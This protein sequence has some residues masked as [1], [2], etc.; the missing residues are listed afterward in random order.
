VRRASQEYVNTIWVPR[1]DGSETLIQ[2][3][4]IQPD[5]AEMYDWFHLDRGRMPRGS[6]IVIGAS[7]AKRL[8]LTI[9]SSLRFGR[10]SWRVVGIFSS[11][12][13][14]A[15]SQIW[16]NLDDL[17]SDFRRDKLS[18]VVLRVGSVNEAS[19]LARRIEHDRRLSEYEAKPEVE[20]YEQEA[21]FLGFVGVLAAIIGICMGIG[22]ALGGMNVFFTSVAQRT[23]E[24]GMLRVLGFPGRSILGSFLLEAA[25]V[26]VVG[27]L[28]GATIGLGS[29]LLHA[30][31]WGA[32][33]RFHVT[34]GIYVSAVIVGTLFAMFG[35][36]FPAI[37]ASRLQ[38]VEA[39]RKG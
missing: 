33:F 19:S 28:A 21:S 4:G 1:D 37:R 3:R 13:N 34:P 12:G 16:A 24:I 18:T 6:E 36:L 39:L 15:E 30:G 8:D 11:G 10:R 32:T 31:F 25:I 29:N 14:S 26:G 27:S 5:V 2:L 9:G 38:A 20:Y 35:G 17:M 23:G 7:A 22:A